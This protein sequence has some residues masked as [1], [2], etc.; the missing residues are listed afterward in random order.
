MLIS[1]LKVFMKTV[2]GPFHPHLENALIEDVRKH[3]S[4]NPFSPLLILVP[5]DSLR[6]RLKICFAAENR[7]NLLNVYIL[8]F[9]QLYLRLSEEIQPGSGASLADDSILE[10]ALSHWIKTGGSQTAGFLSVAEKAGGCGAL[11]QTLRDLRDGGVN[12]ASLRSALDEGLCDDR[13]KDKLAP[14]VD[15]YES[16]IE[17]CRQ[18]GIR[19]Y[20]DF[21]SSVRDSVRSSS[22]LSQFKRIFYYGFYDLTQVQLDVLHEVVRHYSATLY[23]PLLRGHPA[24]IFAE[25]FYERYLQGWAAEEE[26]MIQPGSDACLLPLFSDQIPPREPQT[27]N[28]RSCTII[29]CS[30]PRDEIL[31]VAKEILRLNRDEGVAFAEIGVAARTLEPYTDWIKEVFRDHRIPISTSAEEPLLQAPLAKAVILLLDLTGKDYLRSHFVQLVSSPFFN[32]S[33]VSPQGLAPRPDVW[34]V[35]TRRLGI[36]KG[37][38]EWTRLKRYLDRDFEFSRGEEGNGETRKV[39]V[40]S[41]QVAILWRLF[42]ELHHDLSGLPAGA[43]WSEYVEWWRTLL[44][45]YLD[46]EGAKA[47]MAESPEQAVKTAIFE[48]LTALSILDRIDSKVSLSHF[49]QTLRRWLERKSVPISDRNLDGVTV[50]DAMAARGS[51]FRTIFVLGLNE[52]LFPRTIR[53]DAFLRDRTRRLMETVLGYKVGEKLAAFDEEKLL[54]TLIVGSATE[55]LYCLYQRSDDTGRALEPSWY[56]AELERALSSTTTEITK[57]VIPRSIRAKKD[58]EPFRSSDFLLPEELAIRLSLE[59]E[60]PESLLNNFP[61]TKALYRPG[62]QLLDFLEDANGKL[63]PYDG[64]IGHL[65]EY[66]RDLC[67]HGVSPTALERYARCPFQFFAVNVLD[68]RPLE[69]PEEQSVIDSSEIGKLIHAVLKTFFQELIDAGYFSGSSPSLQ[70][71]AMLEALAR[72]VFRQYEAEKPVG[73]RIIW[74]LLQEQMIALLREQIKRDLRELT[75]SRRRPVALEIELQGKL[76]RDWPLAAADLPILGAVDRID[77]DETNAYYRVIDYKFTMRNKSSTSDNNLRLAA[78]RGEKLQPPIYL[79]LANE[80]ARR[81]TIKPAAIESAFYYLAPRWDE[82]PLLQKTFSADDL[83]G[84]CGQSLRETISLLVRGIHDGLYFIHPGDACRNC[85]VAHVCRK[86]HLPTSWRAA[87]DVLTQ[88]YQEAVN[89]NIPKE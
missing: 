60:D 43:S 33:A 26:H 41:G 34:D 77:L 54:F 15:L 18:W 44:Q 49:V 79:L 66:W 29:S 85:E 74:E 78:V 62:S 88:P 24:W 53:E 52:G 4:N 47:L 42:T 50:L 87:N 59:G 37:T 46:L 21:V 81:Q 20:A 70:P 51:R 27:A 55:R 2:L 31:T 6:R 35:L 56:L 82:G 83:E 61:S 32:L 25:R 64:V 36:T 40:G 10:E 5:S 69:R 68:L 9:H 75:Q 65:P 38:D 7:V 30:G 28:L 67:Q 14:L 71:E 48:T 89:K 63:S 80:F 22:F 3:K 23:F 13:D 72:K 1:A 84:S 11:W 19:D 76:P 8:T 58:V 16:F 12:P 57:P 86:N 17:S 39:R 73:Y 45:K